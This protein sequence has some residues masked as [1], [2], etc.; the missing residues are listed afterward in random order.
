MP[1]QIIQNNNYPFAGGF[2]HVRMGSYRARAPAAA[3]RFLCTTGLAS[4]TALILTGVG[5]VG[6]GGGGV[7][8]CASCIGHFKTDNVNHIGPTIQ[9][10]IARLRTDIGHNIIRIDSC[11]VKG[12]GNPNYPNPGNQLYLVIVQAC[13]QH[14]D[15]RDKVTDNSGR[16]TVVYDNQTRAVYIHNANVGAALQQGPSGAGALFMNVNALIHDV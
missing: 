13:E 9:A 12:S 15:I 16:N 8:R 6:A 1:I 11:V 5:L 4:C 3:Q 14:A 2:K 7:A 10:M